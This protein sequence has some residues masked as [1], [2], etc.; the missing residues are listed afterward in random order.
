MTAPSLAI[1]VSGVTALEGVRDRAQVKPGE[2]VLV[3]GASGGVGTFAVQIAKSSGADVTGVCSTARM[4]LVQ[5]LGAD[6][7]VDY[8]RDDVPGGER[9]YDVILD[10]GGNSRLSQ[11]R[12]ALTPGEPPLSRNGV[13]SAPTT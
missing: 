12:R 9:R 13:V 8:R 2:K 3:I 6:H 7:V 4:D 1:P 11:L 5:A 10:I